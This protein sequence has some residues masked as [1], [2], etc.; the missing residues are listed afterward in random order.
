MRK[1]QL[2]GQRLFKSLKRQTLV[3]ACVLV[4]MCFLLGN[5]YYNAKAFNKEVKKTF[6]KETR[7]VNYNDALIASSIK[8]RGFM[9]TVLRASTKAYIKTD[10]ILAGGD[11]CPGTT[12]TALPY[13]DAA[14][15]TVGLVDDYNMATDT[16]TPTVTGCPTCT[17]TGTGPAASLPRG[18]SYTGTGTGPDSAYTVT[19]SSAGNSLNV[20]MTP[21][22]EDLSLLVY[23][24]V[25]S[26]L[27]PDAIV[28]SDRGAAAQ[29]ETVTIS[30]MP[31]GTYNIVVDGYGT[32]APG[33]SG[34]YT[35]AVTGSGTIG[36]PP[37]A[38]V[39]RVVDFN[40]DGKT[41]YS[42]TRN[43][44]NQK[45]FLT[46]LNGSAT[47]QG[48]AWGIPT[49]KVIS[50]DFDGDLKSDVAV[51]RPGAPNVAAFYI[52]NSN[53]F[54]LNQ[55]VFGQTG[56]DPTVV[57]DYDG[58]G[59][60]DVATYRAGAQS[61]WYY[62]GSL[63]NP[64]GNITYT[65]WGTTGDAPAPG[66]YD[67]N[68]RADFSVQ[69]VSGLPT[70]YTRLS[71]G[72][73]L[74]P[75]VFGLANDFVVPGDYDGDGKTDIATARANGSALQWQWLRSS[76]S[77]LSVQSFGNINLDLTAQGDYDGDGKTDMAVWRIG[78]GFYVQGSAGSPLFQSWGTFN[79]V[80][81]A[82]FN[83]HFD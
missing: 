68:G 5:D 83:S 16:T 46:Q 18:A 74:P 79:D 7:V 22:A 50:G 9:G 71:T 41:D 36:A 6:P 23:T 40:G 20:T 60:T 59:K 44:G 65:P 58:D 67:G 33:S 70:F 37:A 64:A 82:S 31:A 11:V 4:V 29:A 19:F 51:W 10:E 63:A 25:C 52:L 21:A 53:G 2:L 32:A 17:A 55:Q 35:L 47:T 61:F 39:Q 1:T 30:A 45:F 43:V 48:A 3:F 73:N 13:N 56:D 72:V 80:P 26:S 75:T 24:N 8:K 28:V 69:R 57:G 76:D 42:V 81:V 62:R 12:I 34:A 27:L 77:V 78:T 38:P 14:G 66:D 49:D 54:T 15:T